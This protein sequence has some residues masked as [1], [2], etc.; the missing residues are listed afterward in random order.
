MNEPLTRVLDLKDRFINKV[1]PVSSKQLVSKS[2]LTKEEVYDI[3]YSDLYCRFKLLGYLEDLG[4]RGS[5]NGRTPTG[6]QIYLNLNIESTKRDV[7]LNN[8]ERYKNSTKVK[9]L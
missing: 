1:W 9:F 8:K 2:I 5:K 6:E 3:E 7:F 4:Y